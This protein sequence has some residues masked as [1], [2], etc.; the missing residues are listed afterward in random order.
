M[1]S[2]L[3]WNLKRKPRQSLVAKLALSYEVDVIMLAECI[4]PI[5]VLLRS[6]NAKDSLYH[7]APGIGCDKISIFTRFSRDFIPPVYEESRI[8]MRQLRLPGATEI[9]LAVVHFPSKLNWAPSSQA[10]ECS[11]LS[12]TIRDTETKIGHTRSVVVGD[13]NMNPFEEGLINASGLHGVMSRRIAE[14]NTR[15]V[16]QREYPFFYNPMWNFLGDAVSNPP[17]TFYYSSAEHTA[18]FWHMF[19]Q[20]LIRPALLDRFNNADL[21]ILTTDGEISFLTANGTPDDNVASDHLPIFF[22]LNL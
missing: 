4:I 12:R 9:L 3:F 6:L 7:Y 10:A 1:T 22:K 16:Q 20:V 21:S 17:G 5:D 19:D 18:Y 2:F 8:T 15:V 13:M 14:R 11:M